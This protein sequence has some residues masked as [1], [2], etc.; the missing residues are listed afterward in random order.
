MALY[1]NNCHLG[2][3]HDLV[4]GLITL[5][6]VSHL[7]DVRLRHTHCQ[8]NIKNCPELLST[9]SEKYTIL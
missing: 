1:V 9:P 6:P 7:G 5:S 3:C 8:I 4:V 2:Q